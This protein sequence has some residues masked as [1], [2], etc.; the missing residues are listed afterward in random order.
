VIEEEAPKTH[1]ISRPSGL[2]I[3]AMEHYKF[4]RVEVI[5]GFPVLASYDLNWLQENLPMLSDKPYSNVSDG[6]RPA[7]PT[8]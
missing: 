4:Y 5:D 1:Y 8:S 7:Q 3:T 6:I 2:V